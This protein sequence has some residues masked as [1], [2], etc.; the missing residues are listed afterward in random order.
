MDFGEAK[1]TSDWAR[2]PTVYGVNGIV[3]AGATGLT[4]PP[5]EHYA[6]TLAGEA[7]GVSKALRDLAAN[8]IDGQVAD[9][10]GSLEIFMANGSSS[11]ACIVV[12]DRTA[13]SERCFLVFVWARNRGDGLGDL[14]AM[15]PA[16]PR[17]PNDVLNNGAW[18]LFNCRIAV[19]EWTVTR[20][21]R[22]I[23]PQP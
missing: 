14:D 4:V 16:S 12:C 7:V 21:F 3:V 22:G 17:L 19:R 20:A 15:R 1:K 18:Q 23:Y 2:T 9:P 5:S 10:Q 13:G 6:A 11:Y 8:L